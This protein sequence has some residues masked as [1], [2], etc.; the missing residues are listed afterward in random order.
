[1]LIEVP[2]LAIIVAGYGTLA[3]KMVG[4]NPAN[5]RFEL[6]LSII[7]LVINVGFSWSQ[8][9]AAC[10]SSVSVAIA[11]FIVVLVYAVAHVPHSPQDMRFCDAHRL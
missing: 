8:L 5:G 7:F 10:A 6:F 2:L 1:M 11:G 9:L 4:L 3:Y